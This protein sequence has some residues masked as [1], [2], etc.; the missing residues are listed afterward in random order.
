M[1]HTLQNK[2]I[3]VKMMSEAVTSAKQYTHFDEERLTMMTMTMTT[4]AISL[5]VYVFDDDNRKLA[6]FFS[7]NEPRKRTH[8]AH[9]EKKFCLKLKYKSPRANWSAPAMDDSPPPE[10]TLAI[11]KD[12]IDVASTCNARRMRAC[13]RYPSPRGTGQQQTASSN[14]SSG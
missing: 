7:T 5:W 8:R 12:I 13:L 3:C 1:T 11:M 10:H 9:T 2:K 4:A 6:N 14:N